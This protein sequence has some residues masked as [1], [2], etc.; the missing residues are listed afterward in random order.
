[1]AKI[2]IGIH[3]L[4]NKPAEATLTDWWLQAINDGLEGVGAAPIEAAQFKMGYWANL[5][6]ENPDDSP[7]PYTA[8]DTDVIDTDRSKIIAIGREFFADV[9]GKFGDLKRQLTDNERI[10]GIRHC[11]RE[12]VVRDLAHYYDDASCVRFTDRAGQQTRAAIRSVLREL[13]EQH[14]EDEILVIGH[15]MGSIV[16]YDVLRSVRDT[17]IRIPHLITIGSPLGLSAVKQK[18]RAEWDRDQKQPRVPE[19][20]TGSWQNYGDPKDLVC[21]DLSVADEY[22]PSDIVQAEDVVVFNGYCYPAERE[23]KHNHHKSYGYLR[24]PELAA[25]LRAFLG[26]GASRA[27]AG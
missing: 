20:L 5:R 8:P 21:A 24:T 1:M 13:I 17:A 7:E 23:T 3:G 14:A 10:E 22:L 2:I 9:I 18:T 11:V 16:A 19:V 4:S 12:K 6:Y 25:R 27:S 26:E 15:S